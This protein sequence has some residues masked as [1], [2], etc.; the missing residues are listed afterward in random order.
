MAKGDKFGT[1]ISD[2]AF[3]AYEGCDEP[4]LFVSVT[5]IISVA[6]LVLLGHIRDLFATMSRKSRYSESLFNKPPKVGTSCVF[7]IAQD[8]FYLCAEVFFINGLLLCKTQRTQ[9]SSA[10]GDVSTPQQE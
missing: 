8:R 3:D 7:Q 10:P 4:G 9:L 6:F 2:E 1:T 5:S